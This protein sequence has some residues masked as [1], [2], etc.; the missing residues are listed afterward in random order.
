MPPKRVFFLLLFFPAFLLFSPESSFA[1]RVSLFAWPEGDNIMTQARFSTGSAARNAKIRVFALKSQEM[2]L[3]TKTDDKGEAA[4]PI[5]P[6]ASQEGLLLRIDAGEGHQNEWIMEKEEFSNDPSQ[7]EM[8]RPDESPVQKKE[9]TTSQ[10]L[11]PESVSLD[12]LRQIVREEVRDALA[13]V[14]KSLAL[15]S[16][17]PIG[18]NEIIGGIGWILGLCGI[19]AAFWAKKRS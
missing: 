7:K 13:P 2:L 8:K 3:E 15:A 18:I 10:S 6:K 14:R 17:H 12:A 5:P 11:S 9:E 4:F 16:E 19:G 1:H